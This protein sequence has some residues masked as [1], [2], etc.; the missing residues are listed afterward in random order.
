M[1]LALLCL[2]ALGPAA[3]IHAPPTPGSWTS[4]LSFTPMGASNPGAF[5][6]TIDGDTGA[7]APYTI[8]VQLRR[9]GMISPHSHPDRRVITVVAGELC[10]GFGPV[11]DPERCTIY[12]EGSY[13]VVPANEPHFSFGKTS[14]SVYQ[15][16]GF[17][18]SAFIPSLRVD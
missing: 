13:F 11:F 1:R 9:G 3:C 18:P 4:G 2:T 17:G 8:R 5:S 12:P 6:V 10:Y 15:E 16:T 7:R 14:D